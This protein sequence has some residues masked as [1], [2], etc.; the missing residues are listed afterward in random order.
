MNKNSRSSRINIRPRQQ[1]KAA[2]RI[3]QYAPAQDAIALRALYSTRSLEFRIAQILPPHMR[4]TLTY[5]EQV[6][7]TAVTTPQTYIFRGNSAFDP[8]QSGTGNQPVGY[9]NLATLYDSIY[10]IGSR[11]ELQLTNQATSPCQVSLA[12]TTGTTT[13]T[14]FDQSQY[15]PLTKTIELDGT[16]RGGSSFV[17][18]VCQK[19]TLGFFNEPY[20]RDFQT[21]VTT[22][23]ARQ[24]YWTICIQSADQVSAISL[25][26]QIRISY[27]SVFLGRKLVA[28]S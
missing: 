12:P 3:G 4:T 22:N 23:P 16:A 20:D 15:Y 11:I 7:Y 8:N 19:S 17:K 25:N 2:S 1:K 27:D 14:T 28:L 26:M 24:W 18:L 10:V 21:L 9:D 13:L 6:N 5:Y